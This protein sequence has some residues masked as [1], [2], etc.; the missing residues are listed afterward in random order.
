M[1]FPRVKASLPVNAD[2]WAIGA[3]GVA[4]HANAP[5]PGMPTIVV[6]GTEGQYNLCSARI[7]ARTRSEW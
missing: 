5:L 4:W 3:A 1:Q 2:D 7:L 6:L